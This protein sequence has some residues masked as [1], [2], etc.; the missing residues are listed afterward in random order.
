MGS[1]SEDRARRWLAASA[2]HDSECRVI[3]GGECDCYFGVKVG[4]LAAEFEA[5]RA[6]AFE[7]AARRCDDIADGWR[8]TEDRARQTGGEHERFGARASEAWDCARMLRSMAALATSAGLPG[9]RGEAGTC[10]TDGP[11]AGVVEQADTPGSNP[12]G[13]NPVRVRPSPPAPRCDGRGWERMRFGDIKVRRLCPG[14]PACRPPCET[15]D[16]TGRVCATCGPGCD[17]TGHADDTKRALCPAC[18]PAG[19]GVERV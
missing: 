13:G 16:G 3:R 10:E 14:C 11:I 6:E 2:E 7:E 18:R 19:T 5:V 1:P 9:T 12:G 8:A 17:G 15:C 4:L